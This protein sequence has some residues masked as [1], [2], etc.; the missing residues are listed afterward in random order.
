MARDVNSASQNYLI[1]NPPNTTASTNYQT[2][3]IAYM[4]KN[5]VNGNRTAQWISVMKLAAGS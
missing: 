4:N 5:M 3:L 2:N 1:A